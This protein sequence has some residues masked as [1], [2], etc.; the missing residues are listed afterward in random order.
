MTSFKM[1]DN[2]VDKLLEEV[3]EEKDLGVFVKSDLETKYPVHQGNKQSAVGF[4]ND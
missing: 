2:G 3:F 4:K 1:S